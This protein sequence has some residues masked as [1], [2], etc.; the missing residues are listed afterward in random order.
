MDK[1][2][3][4]LQKT[5]VPVGEQVAKN[6]YLQTLKNSFIMFT[7]FLIVGSI[8]LLI[9]NFPIAGYEE[10]MTNIFGEG[11][12]A[13]IGIPFDATYSFMAIFITYLVGYNYAKIEEVDAPTSGILAAI[14]FLILT[15]LGSTEELG[16]FL[17]LEWLGSN[18][19][20][21]G[22]ICAFTT[23]NVFKQ[24]IRR[25]IVIKMPEQVPPE[26]ARSFSAIIP[27]GVI[28]TGSLVIREIFAKTSFET[29]HN[30][31][32][33]VVAAPVGALG[34]SY[35]GTL[36]YSLLTSGL[37][38]IGIN[39]TSSVNSIMRPFWYVNGMENLDA[40]QQGIS[41]LPNVIA[42]PFFDMIHMGGSGATLCLLVALF[43][44]AKSKQSK[45]IR[46]LSITPGVFNINEPLVFGLPVI[47][48]PILLIPFN[49]VPLVL[50]TTQFIAM[51]LNIVAR[52]TGVI[53]PWTTPPIISGFLITGHISG[54]LMQL[55]NLILGALI[56]LPF[57]KMIDRQY[58]KDEE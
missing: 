17:P 9:S 1:L 51:S 35:V 3:K 34:T 12:D 48:N 46:N 47:L 31:V 27:A 5:L 36:L 20:F 50:I 58:V 10:F 33:D 43:I 23:V 18:G 19:I 45:T 15:P 30:F 38:S 13:V 16:T 28:I 7:P 57:L 25:D 53:V 26:V 4:F 32:F 49:L 54:S 37:W 55:F 56:Y 41:P 22:F 2:E 42:E 24:F 39:A 11:W 6:R 40:L 44:G 52:P 21:V 29:I 8:F 14:V